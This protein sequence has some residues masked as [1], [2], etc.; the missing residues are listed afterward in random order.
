MADAGDDLA[1]VVLE[2]IQGE[3]GVVPAT[4]AYLRLARDL[5]RDAGALLVL[6]EV[7]S[8]MGRTGHWLAHHAPTSSPTR[9]PWPR[10]W[11][12]ECRSAPWSPT[13]PTS[14]GC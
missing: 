3:A 7:Q 2:P 6:D 10:G 9:S 11:P 14:P 5:T 12:G 4:D 8:G 13:G 1:A